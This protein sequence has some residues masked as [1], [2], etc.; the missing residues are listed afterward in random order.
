[1]PTRDESG[2][3]LSREDLLQ[4]E[5][6]LRTRHAELTGT[7]ANETTELDDPLSTA[8]PAPEAAG[9]REAGSAVLRDIHAALSQSHRVELQAIVSA[10]AR[11]EAGDYGWC[12]ACGQ[13]IGPERL[14]AQPAALR[15]L[16][17]QSVAERAESRAS[18]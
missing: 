14:A 7:V 17:C 10:L 12:A 4:I 11:M 1:M 9:D 5:H 6:S 18:I 13:P 8:V 15:C 2:A 3:G 16:R